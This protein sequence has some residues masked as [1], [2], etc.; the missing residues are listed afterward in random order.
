MAP[1]PAK[2]VTIKAPIKPTVPTTTSSIPL[3][4]EPAPDA[5]IPFLSTLSKSTVYITHIDS[6]PWWLKRRIFS[7]PVLLNISILGLLLWRASTQI[8]FY[9]LLLASIVNGNPNNTT[10]FYKK[11]AWSTVIWLVVK[12]AIVFLFDWLLVS[13]VAPWPW[14]FFLESTDSGG[15]PMRWRWFVGFRD[16]EVYV[17]ASRG[18]GKQELVGE[19]ASKKGEESPFF[20][21]RVL[22]A[23]DKT[24]LREKTGYL[25]MDKDWDLDFAAMVRATGLVDR[26]EVAL[27]ALR[28]S[29][30]V[31]VGDEEEGKWCV[32]DCWKLDEG[33]ES[34][35][36]EKIILFK[37]K[38][39]AMGKEN[40]FFKWV[41]LVQYESSTPGGFTEERQIETA[42]KAK[43]MFEEQGVD[44]ES[45]VRE[46]GG[47]G[48]LPGMDQDDVNRPP[49]KKK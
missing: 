23:L 35:A 5:L 31:F 40:L 49:Q 39:T 19:T 6:S 33:S 11:G 45:F 44:F 15:N 16:E 10:I 2:R 20:K 46:V 1:K 8:P 4:F 22:P 13:V 32:W 28:K 26:K 29:V 25:L 36:R 47:L 41:E 48:G 18:W 7:I 21:T 27:D 34:L 3:P 37:D 42:Q 43:V 14:S 9:L 30:F 12:R 17:R 24:R 38:L